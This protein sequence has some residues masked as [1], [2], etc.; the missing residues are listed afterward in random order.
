[1][2]HR[3]QT[4]NL[5]GRHLRG[6][7]PESGPR[8]SARIEKNEHHKTRIFKPAGLRGDGIYLGVV[9][10]MKGEPAKLIGESWGTPAQSTWLEPGHQG[11]SAQG[12]LM[13]TIQFVFWSSAVLATSQPHPERSSI[14][15]SVDLDNDGLLERHELV[16]YIGS[17]VQNELAVSLC[18]RTR[19]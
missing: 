10:R 7:K 14:F 19:C 11:S 9:P 16:A 4:W 5:I 8:S 2:R 3:T 18:L 12:E 13:Q 6:R 1:V 15:S 17:Q